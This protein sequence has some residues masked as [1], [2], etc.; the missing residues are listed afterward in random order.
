VRR[1]HA[2]LRL[3]PGVALV[4]LTLA[5]C[6]L[7][8][9]T[10]PESVPDT[11]IFVQGPVDTVN[12]V[13]HLHWWG[14]DPNGYIAGFDVRLLNP[15][16]PADTGWR[17]TTLRDSVITVA[18][19]TGFT[20]AVFEVRA[21]NDRGVKD[22]DPARQPFEFRNEPPVLRLLGKP[23]TAERSDTTFASVTVDWSV[24]D[25]DGDASR[26]VCRVWLDGQ[27]DAP[28]VASGTSF[29]MPSQLF[30]Q[31]GAYRS[32]FRTL[33]LQGIDDGGMA[34]PVDSVRWYVRQ[35]VSGARPRLLLV[36]GTPTTYSAN[37]RADTLYANAVAGTGLD[38]TS[39]T[40]L[41][42]ETNQPFRSAKDLEQT[43]KQFE[44]VVWYRGEQSALPTVLGT[45]GGG[46]GP[47]VEAGGRMFIESLSL[48]EAMSTPGAFSLDFVRRYLNCDGV[49]QFG[50]APDSSAAWG[51]STSPT[52]LRC[53]ALGDSL[54][55]QRI[56]SGLRAFRTRDPAQVLVYV[57]AGAFTQGNAFEMAVA[58]D[59]PQAGGGQL[60]VDSYPMVSA[61]VSTTGFPQRASLVLHKIL[62]R[63][64]LT[65]P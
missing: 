6:G 5:G 35:P 11:F 30:L 20:E 47:Y 24:S 53:P 42:L 28:L 32:G 8:S 50:L 12:H 48:T 40:V 64:G 57:P 23:N 16:A 54:L 9:I 26:V 41:R 34:G 63:L 61:T 49:F 13:V 1:P 3:V 56:V 52:V 59:V 19:P 10:R 60:I 38:P 62:G 36:D 21:I 37:F 31:G 4:A 17:F 43:L 55:N 39:W 27:A 45:Y 25:P 33:Y 14:T 46:I 22:P 65:G 2:I 29:T 18:T 51:L 44:V 7:K 15:A 58:L